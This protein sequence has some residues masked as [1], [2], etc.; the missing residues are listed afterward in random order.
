MRKLTM[1]ELNRMSSSEFV[2]SEK[3]RI[4]LILENIR[5][6]LN[7]GSIFRIA[8]AFALEKL[9]LCGITPQPPHREILKTALGATDSVQWEYR[10]DAIS[11]I[12]DLR[13]RRY[14]IW[15]VEQTDKSHMLD[16]WT[17]NNAQPLALIFGNEV[18]GVSDAVLAE[19]EESIEIPQFGT[20]HSL[21]VAVSVGIVVWHVLQ[22]RQSR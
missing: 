5:S 11:A 9:I 14:V 8:D 3:R 21:N 20:K 4:T 13:K 10:P 6:G 15:P 7:V 19:L 18:H 17:W 22:S 2:N 12:S 16:N 1:A